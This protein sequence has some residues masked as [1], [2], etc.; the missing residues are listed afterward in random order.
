MSDSAGRRLP[1]APAAKGVYRRLLGYLSP[2]RGR[3]ALGMLGGVIFSASMVSFAWLAKLF[4]DST[5]THP[6]PRT[7]LWVP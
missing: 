5:S 3:F 6:D 7:V 2:H 4:A 1:I